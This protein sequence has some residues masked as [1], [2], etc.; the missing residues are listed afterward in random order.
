MVVGD[1][2]QVGSVGVPAE[3]ERL[4]S[5]VMLGIPHVNAPAGDEAMGGDQAAGETDLDG[6]AV[7][8][9]ADLDLVAQRSGGT[10]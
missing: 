6:G 8:V 5:G 4:R 7:D 10:E 2:P 9:A 1:E 3:R